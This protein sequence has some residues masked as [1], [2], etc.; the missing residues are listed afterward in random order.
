MFNARRKAGPDTLRGPPF[1]FIIILSLHNAIRL[2]YSSR[3]MD[4][5]AGATKV[6]TNLS[7]GVRFPLRPPRAGTYNIYVETFALMLRK[8]PLQIARG[9]FHNILLSKTNSMVVVAFLVHRLEA[10][11]QH[12]ASSQNSHP[13]SRSHIEECM[14]THR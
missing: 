12:S 6:S 9:V 13:V 2:W 1:R 14:G 4:G 3:S 10:L 5:A 7:S 11:H 8:T